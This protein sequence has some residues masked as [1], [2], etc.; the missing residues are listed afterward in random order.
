MSDIGSTRGAD[1]GLTTILYAT[2]DWTVNGTRGMVFCDVSGLRS[3]VERAAELASVGN[4]IIA[5]VR[6]PPT[7]TYVVWDQIVRLA[8]RVVAQ[9]CPIAFHGMK[10]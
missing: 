4:H 9:D 5:I 1:E 6:R 8:A 2:D 3:A 7:E 10:P